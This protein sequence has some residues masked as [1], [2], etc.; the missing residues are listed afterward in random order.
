MG[1]VKNGARRIFL[2]AF[3]DIAVLI[4]EIWKHTS[5]FTIVQVIKFFYLISQLNAI[6][7]ELR[8]DFDDLCVA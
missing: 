2:K 4:K 3:R 8:V 7:I 1:I 5:F 6:V